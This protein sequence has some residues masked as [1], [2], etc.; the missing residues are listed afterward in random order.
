M[1]RAQTAPKPVAVQT[2]RPERRDVARIITLPG[3]IVPIEEATLYA[4]VPGYLDKIYVD[5]G[6]EVRA[7]QLIASIRAPELET[8]RQ[9]ALDAYQ[10]SV[11][12]TRVSRATER[13]S[14]EEH[15]RAQAAAEKARADYAQAPATVEKARAQL[16]QAEGTLRR[17]QQLKSVAEATLT[18]SRTQ[19]D[20][21]QAD[22]EAAQSD[23]HL[24]E[25]TYARYQG[26]YQKD[27]KLVARQQVDEEETKAKAAQSKSTA[28]RVQLEAARAHA[29]SAEAQV[30]AAE[31]QIAEA[32][33]G[34]LAAKDAVTV[35]QAQQSSAAK[36][37][38]MATRDIEVSRRQQAVVGA[39]TEQAQ[40]QA[41]AQRSA[42]TRLAEIAAYTRIVAP[43][44]GT[45]TKRMVDPGAFIQTAST[46]QNAAA[47]V[48]I[49]N[50]DALRIY[51]RV[52]ES[53]AD[54]VRPGTVI[55]ISTA[56]HPDDAMRAFVTRTSAALDPRSRTL[57][58]E[59][60]VSN[61]DRRLLP[62][63]YA[64]GK[65]E[66]EHHRNVISVP[67]QAVGSEKSGKFV[68]VV[69]GGKAKR[70]AV[71]TGFDN[72]TFAEIAGG[73]TGR[74]AVVVTGRDALT[75]GA[76]VS[77]T[78]WAPKKRSSSRMRGGA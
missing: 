28:A 47:I 32:Q 75:P 34:V 5:K 18:E 73:L 31:Q 54:L 3:D 1:A 6:D 33:A 21:A 39:Q 16:L 26:I 20:K 78:R 35:A 40:F 57:L 25:V 71:I 58:A 23:Q 70:V 50:V 7:G 37:V 77:V 15:R 44:R 76:P 27:S 17:A 43:F 61:R 63:T 53:E 36:Q 11:Q 46:S 64:I 10:S 42:A 48:T 62:G 69:D 38:E 45:I 2:T 24:A 41:G 12:A 51:I 55:S 74:E 13:R 19:I 4:K 30:G 68:F 14:A 59:V 52:P 72:G 9:Q 29:H 66:L 56:A 60:D 65:V 22:L 67:S 8:E 49:A